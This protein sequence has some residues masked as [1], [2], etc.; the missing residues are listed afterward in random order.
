MKKIIISLW[1]AVM[2]SSCASNVN[3]EMKKLQAQQDVLELNTKLNALKIKRMKQEQ[4]VAKLQ[5]EVNSIDAKADAKTDR[6]SAS[7]TDAK[8]TAKQANK[9]AALLKKTEKANKK[10]FN[11]QSKLRKIDDDI[12]KIQHKLEQHHKG[13]EFTETQP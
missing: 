10:L 1:I 8:T 9:T 11:S 5:A 13:I 3:P 6:F 12:Q 4:E 7:D 2:L